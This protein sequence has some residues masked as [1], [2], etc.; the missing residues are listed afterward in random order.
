[1]WK[2]KGVSEECRGAVF[3]LENMR[4][5]ACVFARQSYAPY[6]SISN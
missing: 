1:M 3:T 5:S 4:M 6:Q 2:E